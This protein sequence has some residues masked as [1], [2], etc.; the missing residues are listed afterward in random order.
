MEGEYY[1]DATSITPPGSQMLIY[2]KPNRR[3]SWGFNAKKARYIGLCFYHY[4]AFWG[5][6]LSTG[7]KRISDTVQFQHHA[8]AIPELTRAYRIL[9]ATRQLKE[10]ITQQPT[11]PP[12]EEVKAK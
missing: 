3:R 8:I 4:R 12:M 10:A 7:A 2:E 9:E 11:T 1:F 5:I 6:V